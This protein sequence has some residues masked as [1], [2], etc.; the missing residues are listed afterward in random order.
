MINGIVTTSNLLTN[1]VFGVASNPDYKFSRMVYFVYV[2]SE[3]YLGCQPFISLHYEENPSSKVCHFH[4]FRHMG[5]IYIV[6]RVFEISIMPVI[7]SMSNSPHQHHLHLVLKNLV[8]YTLLLRATH[9]HQ[10]RHMHHISSFKA[11]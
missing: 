2:L 10:L 9:Q 5:E 8:V 1:R 7:I 4:K 6:Y 3:T 11:L